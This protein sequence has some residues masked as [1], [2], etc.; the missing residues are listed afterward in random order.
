MTLPSHTQVILG[1]PGTGKTSTLLGLIEDELE[2]GTEPE[3]IGFFT[4]T[5]KAVNEGKERAMNRFSITNKQL[6]FF[7]TLHSLA[8]RQLGLTRESVVSNS[9]ISDL[10]E[11]L[12]LKL[13]GR[14]TSDDGHLFGMTHDGS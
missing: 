1:P 4:F 12:N 9:D 11:K 3:R 5:K 13:T 8:F 7:R 2:N 10:N 14:T 6:P